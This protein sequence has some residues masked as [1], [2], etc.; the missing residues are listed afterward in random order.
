[1]TVS[2]IIESANDQETDISPK[3]KYKW[4]IS[5]WKTCPVS[6]VIREMQINNKLPLHTH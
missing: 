6:L 3:K 1:M 2:L 5:A 4:S